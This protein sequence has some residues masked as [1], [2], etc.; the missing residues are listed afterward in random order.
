[1]CCFHAGQTVG[2]SAKD[3]EL[4]VFIG[5]ENGP[6]SVLIYILFIP[7]NKSLCYCYFPYNTAILWRLCK[8][9]TLPVFKVSQ[10]CFLMGVTFI[11]SDWSN[12]DISTNKSWAQVLV[13]RFQSCCEMSAPLVLVLS[14]VLESYNYLYS[15][16]W[17]VSI[18][19]QV[20]ISVTRFP[21]N[22]NFQRSRWANYC[23]SPAMRC[24][25]HMYVNKYL[26]LKYFRCTLWSRRIYICSKS[27]LLQSS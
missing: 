6:G 27:W 1:M 26:H 15:W 8:S 14:L 10:S 22:F 12:I 2:N 23:F 3:L 13:T 9:L 4:G 7:L 25:Q 5:W 18:Q 20:L 16:R 24:L 11:K 17:W 21:V 19:Q